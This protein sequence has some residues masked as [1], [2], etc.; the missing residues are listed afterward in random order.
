MDFLPQVPPT[1]YIPYRYDPHVVRKQAPDI[2]NILKKQLQQ[3][4][5]LAG[6]TG[7]VGG[8]PCFPY[9]DRWG[10]RPEDYRRKPASAIWQPAGPW[11]EPGEPPY[12]GPLRI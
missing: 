1:T 4:N 6:E 12:W 7:Y 11:F 8:L 3:Q 9:W 2:P 10:A 5:I